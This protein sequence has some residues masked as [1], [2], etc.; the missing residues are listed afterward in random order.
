MSTTPITGSL[1]V[2]VAAAS[3]AAGALLLDAGDD[4]PAA[5]PASSAAPA[6]DGGYGSSG[7]APAGGD[8]ASS[9]GAV[10]LEISG[11]QFASVAVD[12]GGQVSVANR[13]SA[14]HTV[15]AD[16]GSFDSGEVDG[17]SAAAIAAPE[18]PGTYEFHCEIHP[19]MSG[20]LTVR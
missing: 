4:S 10:P 17:G 7:P 16:D 1:V 9:G 5:A 19:D 14:P 2:C 13:D 18:A 12:A 20:T 8:A 6:A 15:T 11:F 3:L